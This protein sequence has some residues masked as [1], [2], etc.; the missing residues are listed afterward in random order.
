MRLMTR[1]EWRAFLSGGTRTAKLALTRRDGQP[2]VVPVWFVL[3]GDDLLF[4]TG[5]SSLKARV[6][7]RD[8]RVAVCVDLEEP[9]F[10]YVAIQGRAS[11]TDDMAELRRVATLVGGRYMG[12]ERAEE[13]GARNAVP[14]EVAVRITPL[15]VTAQD[16]I[17]D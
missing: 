13:F 3:E 7:A 4:T 12:Q 2:F 15:R 14:G 9:P 16:A 10:A 6:L 8:P 1:E 17:A 11:V 5:A